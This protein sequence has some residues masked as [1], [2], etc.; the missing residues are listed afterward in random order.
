[1][2]DAP[3]Y[4]Q[5]A[6]EEAWADHQPGSAFIRH[7]ASGGAPRAVWSAAP[8]TDWPRLIAHA[9]AATYAAGRGALICV[10]D[11]KDVARVSEALDNVLGKR[12]HVTLTADSGPARR[13]RDFLAVRR[14]ARR[15]VVGTRAAAF[16]PVHDL[17]LVV[18]WDDGDDLHAEP[19]APYPHTRETLLLRAEREHTA[20]LV[21]GYARTVEGAF[22]V[23]AKWAHALVAD[24]AEIRRRVTVSVAG[25]SVADLRRDPHA[26]GAR[27][28]AEV[29]ETIRQA[30]DDGPV[31]VQTPRAG[32]VNALACE[33]CRTPARCASC[34]G[35]LELR[36]PTTPPP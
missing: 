5:Q 7:L 21:G 29:H 25:A 34:Q 14:G 26:R 1:M 19:R 17:G 10:P 24:R 31:L 22:L 15:I 11:H 20:A 35:P 18:V 8:A 9:V 30:L 32:Y 3:S 12:H 27:I 28:P 2:P 36:G 6:A 33:R 4:D 23:T 16:A 13:Y